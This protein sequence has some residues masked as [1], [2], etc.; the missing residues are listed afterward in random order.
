MSENN[1]AQLIA[2]LKQLKLREL[3]VL[4]TLESIVANQQS[5]TITTTVPDLPIATNITPIITP[6]QPYQVGDLIVITNK[7]RRPINR[8]VNRGDQLAIILKVT[9]LRIDLRTNNGSLTWRAPHN[10]R[11][12]SQDD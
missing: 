11:L 8:S 3:Q 1:I 12:R 6:T 7:I 9:P 5:D 10:I 4:A 2:E